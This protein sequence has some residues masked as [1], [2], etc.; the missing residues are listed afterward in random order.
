MK[1]VSKT[2]KMGEPSTYEISIVE[3]IGGLKFPLG[4]NV[5]RDE[6]LSFIESFNELESENDL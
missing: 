3:D 2:K 4:F 6:I 5:S 1:L